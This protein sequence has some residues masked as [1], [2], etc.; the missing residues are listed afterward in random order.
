M[1]E[2]W[3]FDIAVDAMSTAQY[4]QFSNGVTDGSNWYKTYFEETS[5]DPTVNPT[6]P[7]YSWG[8]MS[9]CSINDAASVCAD[10]GF[11]CKER[12]GRGSHFR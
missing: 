10:T 9:G 6:P 11:S 2:P 8:C 12:G 1:G 4:N 5:C 3:H 7:I